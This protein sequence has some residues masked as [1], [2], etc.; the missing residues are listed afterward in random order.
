MKKIILML[1]L[2]LTGVTSVAQ[3]YTRQGTNFTQVAKEKTI[4][5]GEVKPTPY[6]WTDSKGTKYPIYLSSKG[7]AFIVKISKKTGKEYK[8]YLGEEISRQICKE[9][10]VDYAE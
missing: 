4:K 5:K 1:L 3:D 2:L 6:T 10:K 7:R 8:Q 9:M